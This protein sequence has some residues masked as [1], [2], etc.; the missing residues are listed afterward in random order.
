MQLLIRL[1]DQN[2]IERS[3]EN[4]A[5]RFPIFVDNHKW[6][7]LLINK[8]SPLILQKSPSIKIGFISLTEELVS[9]SP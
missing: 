9:R 2:E 4:F 7:N 1:L 3:I 5:S 6:I 8:Y